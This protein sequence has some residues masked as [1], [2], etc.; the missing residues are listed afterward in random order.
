MKEIFN[1]FKVVLTKCMMLKVV[2]LQ[3]MS[4]CCI[5]KVA[6]YCGNGDAWYVTHSEYA[7]EKFKCLCLRM[8]SIG[9]PC[10]HIVC[11][12]VYLDIDELP[13]CLVLPRWTKI[14]KDSINGSYPGGSLYWDSQVA[15]RYS[16][17]VKMSKDV[18]EMAY[19]DLDDYN[20]V[21]DVLDAELNRLKAKQ[22][23]HHTNA[24]TGLNTCSGSMDVNVL[25]PAQFRTKGCGSNPTPTPGK[26]RRPPTC[27]DCTQVGHNKRFCP[28]SNTGVHP[29]VT[30]SPNYDNLVSS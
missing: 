24:T 27:C 3:Q 5:Y 12:L 2:E 16:S 26:R 18:A 17:L 9:L 6:K 1:M 8:E 19:H 22:Q 14:A 7:V 11:V 4:R 13:K 25:D 30:P 28:N 10:H 21:V 15:A 23:T 29:A 20:R